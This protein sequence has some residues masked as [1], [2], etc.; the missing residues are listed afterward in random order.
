MDCC[1]S[2]VTPRSQTQVGKARNDLEVATEG[3]TIMS[4]KYEFVC[5]SAVKWNE[6]MLF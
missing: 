3:F 6:F 4:T 1:H 2:H 5:K